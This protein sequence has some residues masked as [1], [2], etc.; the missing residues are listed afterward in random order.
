MRHQ[1]TGKV[2]SK[3]VCSFQKVFLVK[4]LTSPFFKKSE[5]KFYDDVAYA[6]R[7]PP[8]GVVVHRTRLSRYTSYK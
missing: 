5:L 2:L 1:K 7:T 6:R 8:K 3:S 4:Y